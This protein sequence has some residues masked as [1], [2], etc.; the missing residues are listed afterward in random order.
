LPS[1]QGREQFYS[2]SN[3]AGVKDTRKN[4]NVSQWVAADTY[5]NRLERNGLDL[6]LVRWLRNFSFRY[7]EC[8]GSA[9]TAKLSA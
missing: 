3:S 4:A 1:Y 5:L 7:A 2:R 9:R 6:R 8:W